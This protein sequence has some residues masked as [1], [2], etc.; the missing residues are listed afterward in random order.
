[1]AMQINMPKYVD[2]QIQILWW[3]ADEF[4][5]AMTIVG[6]GLMMHVFLIPLVI[7]FFLVPVIT[8]MKRAALEGT[9]MHVLYATGVFPLNKEFTDA[10]ETEFYL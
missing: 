8:K 9:A 3:E 2:A 1:M 4:L 7:L 5:I 6:V 10:L